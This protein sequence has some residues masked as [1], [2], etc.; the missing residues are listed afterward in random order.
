MLIGDPLYPCCT[1]TPPA[2]VTVPAPLRAVHRQSD[3]TPACRHHQP[4]VPYQL[5][6]GLAS[7]YQP[8]QITT[9]ELEKEFVTFLERDIFRLFRTAYRQEKNLHRSED[10]LQDAT[11]NMWQKW[12]YIRIRVDEKNWAGYA[13]SCVIRSYY[14][15]LKKESRESGKG[16]KLRLERKTPDRAYRNIE[17]ELQVISLLDLLPPRQRDILHMRYF[18]GLSIANIASQLNISVRTVSREEKKA[19][20]FLRETEQLE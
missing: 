4:F 20:E 16:V 13:S 7:A 9:L 1:G 8:R 19:M 3:A 2:Q 10:V 14:D 15:L 6:C 12:R 18:E 17:E 5:A 11:S